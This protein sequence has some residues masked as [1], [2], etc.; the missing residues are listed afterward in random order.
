MSSDYTV[1]QIITGRAYK[2][3]N[4]IN[5]D[6]FKTGLIYETNTRKW[7]IYDEILEDWVPYIIETK[8]VPNETLLQGNITG[9]GSAQQLSVT[10]IL[11][12]ILTIQSHISNSNLIYVSN[13]NTVSA[14]SGMILCPG[15]SMTFT[16]DNINKIW[17]SATA[18]NKLSYIAEV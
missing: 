13:A 12:K 1:S 15:D 5:Y 6:A 14:T 8:D 10:S 16:I 7:Y 4:S 2:T 9:S 11:C 17:I 3:Q 18:G